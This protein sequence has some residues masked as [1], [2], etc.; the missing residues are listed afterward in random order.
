MARQPQPQQ[1]APPPEPATTTGGPPPLEAGGVLTIDLDAIR[2]NY[3]MLAAR[4]VPGE[5]AA[6]VKGDGYGCGIEQVTATLERAG[7]RTFF[8][9]HLAEARRVRAIAPEAAIYVLNG[10]SSA[11]GP[12]FV[13]TYARPV[14]NS[15]VELAE[16]DH[17]VAT[18]GWTG[19][20]ALHIDTGMNRLG[21]TIE[22]AVAVAHRIQSEN[23]GVE[24]LMSHLACAD[25][26]NHPLNDQQIRQ[27]RELRSLFRG[28]SSSLANSAGIFLDS[29]TYCDLVRPGVALYGGNP[30]PG[31]PNPMR[32]VIDLK[33]RI[34]QV[35][36][37]PRGQTVGYGATWTAKRPSRIAVIAAGY[38]DGIP[39]AAGALG[40]EG[41]PQREAIVND[42]RCKVVGRV[43]MDLIA[44]DVTDIPEG[45]VR[46]D[47]M[48]TLIGAGLSLEEAATQAGTIDY[49]LLTSLGR[50]YH[51]IWKV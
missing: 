25:Q 51:R 9:A 26:T 33:C 37:V 47:A 48:A 39:R 30:T 10:F 43:S 5:C 24:L 21:L 12:A 4:V 3:R 36:N 18:S 15:S 45:A 44:V 8:V 40:P 49:E 2:T 23:H 31:R 28:I 19:G 29:S 17:F 1:P 32:Q 22:E 20:A 6:V 7:C 46:R 34:L 27:F 16:W 41:A 11:A 13:E 42:R 35:R 38:A 50:R 14:I